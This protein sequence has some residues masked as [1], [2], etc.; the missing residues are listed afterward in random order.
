MIDAIAL[1]LA[2]ATP[3]AVVSAIET[4]R[5]GFE[6]LSLIARRALSWYAWSSGIGLIVIALSAAMG[7]LDLSSPR[8]AAAELGR[9]FVIVVAAAAF[10]LSVVRLGLLTFRHFFG[11]RS[12]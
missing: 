3:V 9:A 6:K 8:T 4:A 5:A 10:A 1:G 12:H 7:A 2:A 11:R